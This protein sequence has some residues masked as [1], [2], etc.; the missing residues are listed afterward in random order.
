[1][2]VLVVDPLEVV[3]VADQDAQRMRTVAPRP[4]ADLG[5]PLGERR[6]VEQAGERIDHG[7]APVLAVGLHDG[8]GEQ[9]RAD[10]QRDGE[11]QRRR[12]VGDRRGIEGNGGG[13]QQDAEVEAAE[14]RPA[15]LEAAG[16]RHGGQREPVDRRAALGSGE[17]DADRD[18]QRR[19]R[20]AGGD[21][22]AGTGALG[23][24][25]VDDR[26]AHGCE[27]QRHQPP[28]AEP[29]ARGQQAETEDREGG[30]PVGGEAGLH[31]EQPLT[32]QLIAEFLSVRVLSLC[33]PF[34]GSDSR[35]RALHWTRSLQTGTSASCARSLNRSGAAPL[36]RGP[37]AVPSAALSARLAAGPA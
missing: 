6:A 2:A 29:G 3:E 37:A 16:E 8:A 20:P 21:P 26:K 5:D 25:A 7:A 14:D 27:Q 4:V 18:H 34:P 33:H 11:D 15:V 28:P 30:L 36:G 10:D 23:K 22:N 19:D 13:D 24:A 31:V 12:V 9:H 35:S 32:P 1:M 17:C